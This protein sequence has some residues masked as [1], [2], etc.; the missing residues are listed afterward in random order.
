MMNRRQFL[1]GLAG[2]GVVMA[3]AT[4][5]VGAISRPCKNR[6]RDLVGLPWAIEPKFAFAGSFCNGLACVALQSHGEAKYGYIN[7]KGQFVIPPRFDYATPFRACY[8]DRAYVVLNG[9]RGYTFKDG[10]FHPESPNMQRCAYAPHFIESD[11][12]VMVQRSEDQKDFLLGVSDHGKRGYIDKDLQIV[13]EPQFDYGHGFREG[14]ADVERNEKCGY[15]DRT[16][17]VVLDFQYDLARPFVDGFAEV[18]KDNRTMLINQAGEEIR[19]SR[20]ESY[21]FFSEGLCT[22]RSG[23]GKYGYVD[24]NGNIAIRPAF[25]VAEDFSDGLAIVA[26]GGKWG[27]IDKHGTFVITPRFD[28]LIL[29]TEGA[30]IRFRVGETT[31]SI[32]CP[33]GGS[34]TMG[35]K[36]GYADLRGQVVIPPE[37]DSSC[38]FQEGLAPTRLKDKWGYIDRTG[39]WVI[40]PL[41]DSWQH[42]S[43]GVAR[44]RIGDTWG[45]LAKP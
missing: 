11:P 21:G 33:I 45:Y 36:Y 23:S 12:A 8:E 27:L 35:G 42:F 38:G 19:G 24:T 2:I 16:G 4:G 22:V 30:F 1:R 7:T 34:Y 18:I 39:Q 43:E 37:F 15:I 9:M 17:R 6:R 14:L 5:A 29:R 44:A 31:G 20:T 10:S 3:G 13:I 40:Q 25:D 32:S 28:N 26:A 41:L